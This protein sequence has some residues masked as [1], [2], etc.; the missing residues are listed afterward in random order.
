MTQPGEM[1][2]PA[3]ETIDASSS[4]DSSDSETDEQKDRRLKMAAKFNPALIYGAETI[5]P[6]KAAQEKVQIKIQKKYR[7]FKKLLKHL[8]KYLKFEKIYLNLV[9]RFKFVDSMDALTRP[10]PKLPKTDLASTS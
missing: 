6:S 10:V 5:V 9:N 4:S 3:G 7:N 1:V 2:T 8:N